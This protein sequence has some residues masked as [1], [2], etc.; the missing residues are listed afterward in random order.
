MVD[1]G[2]GIYADAPAGAQGQAREDYLRVLSGLGD[3]DSAREY[4]E[5]I[6]DSGSM[7]RK[8]WFYAGTVL[9]SAHDW[10]G[11]I[12]NYTRMTDRSDS[13]GQ[14]ANY[15]LGNAYIRTRNQVAAMEAFREAAAVDYDPRMTEDAA[16]NYAK[17]AFDLNKDTSGF[18]DYLKALFHQGARGADLRLHGP[19]GPHRR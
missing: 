7:N 5:Q 11:A 2:V 1:Q 19:R 16:F 12:E 4:Y 6:S 9:Y 13:L 18:A 14:I 8:D 15:H 3:V 10:Q 17:L